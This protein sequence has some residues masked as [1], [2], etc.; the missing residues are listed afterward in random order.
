[1]KLRLI[2][3]DRDGVINQDSPDSY[4]TTPQDW[5]PIAGSLDALASMSNAGYLVGVCTNQSGI[6]RGLYSTQTLH[7]I[8]EKMVHQVTAVGGRID[9][10]HFCPHLPDDDCACRKPKPGL[11]QDAMLKMQV[12]P[13]NTVFVGDSI[14]DVQAAIAAGCEPAIVATGNGQLAKQRF[15]NIAAFDDLAAFAASVCAQ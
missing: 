11:L 6:G 12:S 2:L 7:D 3:L 1:M 13:E 10:I 14:R 4:I 9:T 8:H 5:L 15:P